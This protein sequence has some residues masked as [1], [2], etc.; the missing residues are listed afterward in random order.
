MWETEIKIQ[1]DQCKEPRDVTMSF[2]MEM[3]LEL[4]PLKMN[5]EKLAP[6]YPFGKN[7]LAVPQK[8]K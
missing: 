1:N 3:K 8:I 2:T 4:S 5:R 6:S 7:S